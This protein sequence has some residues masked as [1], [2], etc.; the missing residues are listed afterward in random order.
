MMNL[1]WKQTIAFTTALGIAFVSAPTVADQSASKDNRTPLQV[2]FIGAAN[3][4]GLDGIAVAGLYGMV[5]LLKLEDGTWK[6]HR[7]KNPPKEDFTAVSA[8]SDTEALVGSSTGRLY[9]YDGKSLTEVAKLSEYS[10]P[11]LDIEAS[12]GKAWAVGARGIIA[13]SPDGRAWEEVE[14]NNVVQPLIT[15]HAGHTADWY[16]GATNLNPDSI[17]F[18]ATVGG[19][20]AIEEE[21]YTMFADEGFVQTTTELDMDVPPTIEFTFNPG[22]PFRSGDVSWNTLLFDGTKL[23]IAGEFGMVL[24]SEDNG[25][26]WVRRDTKLVDGEPE[27]A[28]WLASVQKGNTIYLAGAAGVS[29]MS[30]D[31][32]ITWTVQPRPG[33]EGIFGIELLDSGEPLVAGAVGLLGR[34]SNDAWALA[35]RTELKLL[36]WLKNPVPLAD[37]SVLMLGGRSTAISFKDGTWTRVPVDVR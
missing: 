18:T 15:W 21:H 4:P 31:G 8:Y 20:P 35:D 14:I 30:N 6:L 13:R 26:T 12:N 32:G 27:S 28:Y 9:L 36:S 29:S 22:P 24:Q 34:Y 19:E 16:F 33:N 7:L 25:E 23:T 11:I 5:G 10:E 2:D 37:G 1:C 3:L 17:K